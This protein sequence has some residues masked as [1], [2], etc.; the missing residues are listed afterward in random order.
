MRDVSKGDGGGGEGGF[1]GGEAGRLG[2]I[3][4]GCDSSRGGNAVEGDENEEEEEEEEEE[5]IN[6][7]T[8]YYSPGLHSMKK[9][10]KNNHTPASCSRK[11]NE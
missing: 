11:R 1:V 9:I 8:S 5:A 4:A 7:D 2:S 3:I 6:L 10:T